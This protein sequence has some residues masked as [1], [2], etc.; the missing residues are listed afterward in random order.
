M[1]DP[2]GP[3]AVV[4]RVEILIC[5]RA[6][7]PIVKNLIDPK[8]VIQLKMVNFNFINRHTYTIIWI[9]IFV[10]II[11]DPFKSLLADN[12]FRDLVTD[13]L[14]IKTQKTT[15]GERSRSSSRRK[16]KSKRTKGKSKRRSST[17]TSSERKNRRSISTERKNR[18]R[19]ISTERK[20]GRSNSTGS[21]PKYTDQA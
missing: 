11:L 9:C 7:V 8:V 12:S 21:K 5:P 14:K 18:R 1:K 19:S 20:N 4:Q 15:S 13:F 2:I 17:S 6:I 10:Y 16:K 3:E